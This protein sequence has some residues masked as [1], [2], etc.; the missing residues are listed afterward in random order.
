MIDKLLTA[1]AFDA[2]AIR[3]GAEEFYSLEKA[4]ELYGEIYKEILFK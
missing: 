2:G 4:V 3:K 1:N